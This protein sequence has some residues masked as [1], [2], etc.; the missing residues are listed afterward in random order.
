MSFQNGENRAQKMVK[1]SLYMFV[2]LSYCLRGL[3]TRATARFVIGGVSVK[4]QYQ[5]SKN[6]RFFG[7]STKIENGGLVRFCL[8]VGGL[9]NGGSSSLFGKVD[10]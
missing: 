10:F 1:V 3:Q 7:K 2:C 4:I 8:V 6:R 5:N 9:L